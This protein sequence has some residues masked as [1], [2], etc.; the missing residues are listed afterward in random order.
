MIKAFIFDLDGT[1]Y[2]R[3]SPLFAAMSLRMKRW[4]QGQVGIG[5]DDLD[6]W[7]EWQKTEYP[8]PLS[9]VQAFGLSASAFH[10]EV[11]GQL[12]P[13]QYLSVDTEL[14]GMLSRLPGRKFIV[15]LSQHDYAARVL[16]AL[17]IR[18]YFPEIL[19][20]G[21]DWQTTSKL[22]AYE[23]IR[24]VY[25]LV[26]AE[27]CV[28]GDNPRIDLMEAAKA[29]YRSVAVS[30]EL[31]PGMT[32]IPAL[33]DLP[34]V[35]G[36]KILNFPDE[37][38]LLVTSFFI[39]SID[40]LA[41][42]RAQWACR[43]E[44]HSN[45]LGRTQEQTRSLSDRDFGGAITLADPDNLEAGFL[46]ELNVP[47]AFG[48][49]FNTVNSAL[50]VTSG[51]VISKVQ[52]GACVK[53]LGNPLFNDLHSLTCSAS[54]NLLVASTGV[55]GILEVDFEEASRVYWDWLATEHG[56]DRTPAG[57]LRIIRR[58]LNYQNIVA[59]TPQHTTHVNTALNDVPQRVLATIFHQGA[60]IEIDRESGCCHVLLEGL[61]SPHNIRRRSGGYMLCDTRA[62]RVLLLDEQFAVESEISNGFDWVQDA[63]E[64]DGNSFL[65]GD[66]NRD[67]IAR[68]SK[69]G[70]TNAVL[71][72]ENRTRKL[73]SL[74]LITARQAREIFL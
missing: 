47:L 21:R 73:G 28:V 19:V 24:K 6:A 70:E 27:I 34:R 74:E 65:V 55:D 31:L 38:Q 42:L 57:D 68:I 20:H 59:S 53:E 7:Y 40:A 72:W 8:T 63:L 49:C 4:F 33:V 48:M 60:L 12:N 69:R 56:Y 51:T 62:N 32:C 30:A 67:R 35:V 52:H 39:T 15:T 23:A 17:G 5:D 29:G 3:K 2:P 36:D 64:L 25:G 16:Q 41:R 10:E 50:Y 18:Q 44:A 43:D 45:V 1:V 13:E 58:E 9:G 37:K 22:D 26:P 11:F 54:G 14:Q 66:S 46:M 61:K 71:S